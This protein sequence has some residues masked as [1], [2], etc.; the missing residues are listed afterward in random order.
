MNKPSFLAVIT[1]VDK[2]AY[3]RKDG[4]LVIPIGCLKP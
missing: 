3:K 4:V 1:A 2:F